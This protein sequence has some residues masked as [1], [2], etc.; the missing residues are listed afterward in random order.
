MR[1]FLLYGQGR[2]AQRRLV[3]KVSK[4]KRPE[5]A[6]FMFS[7]TLEGHRCTVKKNCSN[8]LLRCP[9]CDKLSFENMRNMLNRCS[10]GCVMARTRTAKQRRRTR[11]RTGDKD[12][13]T[14][15]TD[16]DKGDQDKP[17]KEEPE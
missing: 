16:T 15:N 1:P 17:R 11:K 4:T 13:E 12:K 3:K 9:S 6:M 5:M 14:E 10:F 2:D 8:A 7:R